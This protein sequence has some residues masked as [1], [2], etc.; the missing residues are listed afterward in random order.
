MNTKA[1][2][3]GLEKLITCP[4]WFMFRGA[5]MLILGSVLSLFT[6]MAPNMQMLGTS[7]SWLPVAASLII[8]VGILR[9]VDAYVSSSQSFLLIYFLGSIIDLVCG[10]VIVFSVGKDVIAFSL[11][12][13]AYL[14]IQGL[15]RIMISYVLRIP[16]SNLARI[17]GTITVLLGI[18][19]WMNWPFSDLWFLSFA[20]SAEVANRGWALIFY[21]NAVNKQRVI[22][23]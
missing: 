17:G 2:T 1:G 19:T 10:V 5:V 6:I 16:N 18:M 21:G 12:I 13:T 14:I 22:S 11:L 9:F 8:L 7:S 3:N 20:L 4:W 23:Q 15:F